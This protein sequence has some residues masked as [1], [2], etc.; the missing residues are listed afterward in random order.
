M[1]CRQLKP[2]EAL[3][4]SS[5]KAATAAAV[6]AGAAEQLSEFV[7]LDDV[8]LEAVHLVNWEEQIQWAPGSPS[9]SSDSTLT[10]GELACAPCHIGSLTNAT[11]LHS[12]FAL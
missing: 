8:D 10:I 2:D 12:C 5:S 1:C 7:V 11:L 9:R 4:V 6:Q 3:Q